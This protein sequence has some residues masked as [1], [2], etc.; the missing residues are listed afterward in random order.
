ME[1]PFTRI[2]SIFFPCLTGTRTRE[3]ILERLRVAMPHLHTRY[4]LI[5]MAVFGS[6]T[7]GEAQPGSDVDILVKLEQ[8]LGRRLDL[9]QS[10]RMK[11]RYFRFLEKDLMYV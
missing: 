7:R 6:V 2:I 11:D 4:P 1:L 10:S 8:L 3:D 9:V 5:R